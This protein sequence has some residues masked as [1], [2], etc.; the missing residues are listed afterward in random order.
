MEHRGGQDWSWF[1]AHG[2]P[3]D[4]TLGSFA[5]G[6]PDEA[7]LLA[8]VAQRRARRSDPG[9]QR[10]FRNDPPIPYNSQQIVLAGQALAVADQVLE[11]PRQD[12]GTQQCNE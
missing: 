1:V 12:P 5:V 9:A 8:A 4:G 10:R 7:M 11:N 3:N 2:S 6:G